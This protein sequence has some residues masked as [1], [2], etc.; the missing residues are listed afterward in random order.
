MRSPA[1][2]GCRRR[3]SQASRRSPTSPRTSR[4]RCAAAV[5][6]RVTLADRQPTAAAVG[7]ITRYAAS[8]VVR[9][10][11]SSPRRLDRAVRRPGRDPSR[12]CDRCVATELVARRSPPAASRP[13]PATRYRGSA[14]CD[15]SARPRRAAVGATPAAR[16]RDRE[17][18][19][20]GKDASL[21]A[22]AYVIR[23]TP[24]TP[25][26][27]RRSP[28]SG[29]CARQGDRRRRRSSTLRNRRRAIVAELTGSRR[30]RRSAATARGRREVVELVVADWTAAPRARKPC[31]K[32][33][34]SR[35]PAAR[36][37]SARRSRASSPARTTRSSTLLGRSTPDATTV[38]LS[39]AD[40]AGGEALVPCAAT[41]ATPPRSRSDR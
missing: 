20:V 19:A 1:S 33:G 28:A 4:S 12:R 39:R 13:A 18:R 35:S 21:V 40:A 5:A 38:E 26:S 11:S 17:A 32:A 25:G 14:Q 9:P 30:E 24:R 6:S 16:S 27:A 23:G 3:C 8:S 37:A 7:P 36:A 15:R 22:F 10:L 34:S 2:K 29:R 41:C 31:A